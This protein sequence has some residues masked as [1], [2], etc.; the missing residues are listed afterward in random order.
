MRELAGPCLRAVL[1][2]LGLVWSLGAN[3]LMPIELM[4]NFERIDTRHSLEALVD[5]SAALTLDEVQAA[6]ERFAASGHT[7]FAPQ[8]AAIWTRLALHNATADQRSVLLMNPSPHVHQIDIHVVRQDDSVESYALGSHRSRERRTLPHRYDV[9]PISLDPGEQVLVYTRHQSA[10]SM[11]VDTVLYMPNAFLRF[12]QRDALS[13]GLFTGL[14]AALVLYNMVVG[15]ALRQRVFLF[16]VLHGVA[17][18]AFTLT[19]NGADILVW[20]RPVLDTLAPAPMGYAV[21][22]SVA[23]VSRIS[24]VLLLLV[25]ITAS[26]F[27]SAFFDL[28]RRSRVAARLVR[29]WLAIA[30]SFVAAEIASALWP[31]LDALD[32]LLA[33]LVFFFLLC[34]LALGVFA[35]LRRYPGWQYY[36]AGTGSFTVLA[37]LQDAEWLGLETGIPDWISAYGTPVGLTLELSMLSLALGQRIRRLAAEHDAS[38]RLLVAQAKFSSVGQLLAGVVHQLKRPVIYAGTQLMKLE[39]LM[40]RPPAEREAE[41]P[42][43]LTDMRATI[44]FMDKTIVD[45][46]RFYSDDKVQQDYHPAE[47][48]EHVVSMLTPMT[49]GSALRIERDLLPEVT[50]H[51]YANAFGHAMMIVLENAAQVLKDRAVPAP[52]IRVGMAVEKHRL[53][54]IVTDNGGGI[55]A[56]RLERIFELYAKAPSRGGL[57]IGLALA[58][59]MIVERL[60]GSI[61]ARNVPGGAE[62][63]IRLPL[64]SKMAA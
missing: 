26:L 4:G 35:A 14:V 52:L 42:K 59:R 2:A 21:S 6:A 60:Q 29:L 43:A 45:L 53:L 18:F 38:E 17:L 49:T 63:T 39:A 51:G 32:A 56:D 23:A 13:W 34:W 8:Q 3:A 44:D 47:Q 7:R 28:P 10:R 19:M 50:L 9:Q 24:H 5:E 40:D 22:L 30:A 20:V 57:G 58:R 1:G 41:L 15:M 12:V 16:Y 27:G 36:L 62:F 46:Y 55:A 25:T 37:L 48:I 54:V 61:R 11:D 33:Y 31:S 64:S